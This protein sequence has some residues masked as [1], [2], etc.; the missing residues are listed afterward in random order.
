MSIYLSKTQEIRNSYA[1]S[2]I[3][4]SIIYYNI[5]KIKRSLTLILL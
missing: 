4:M 3:V 5:D 2:V 1:N